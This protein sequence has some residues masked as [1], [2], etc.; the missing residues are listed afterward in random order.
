MGN[1]RSNQIREPE[2]ENR[3]KTLTQDL[4]GREAGQHANKVRACAH[5]GIF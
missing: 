3:R 4:S 5:G 2:P 1:T